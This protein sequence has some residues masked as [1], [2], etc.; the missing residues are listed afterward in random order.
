MTADALATLPLVSFG[1]MLGAFVG[2]F[3]SGA[4][5]DGHARVT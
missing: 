4:C 2:A 3:S 1:G 5:S